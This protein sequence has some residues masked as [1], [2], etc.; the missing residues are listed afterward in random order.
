MPE[1]FIA[2][3]DLTV[4]KLQL[5]YDYFHHTGEKAKANRFITYLES[6]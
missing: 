5:L 2:K 6:S 1:S 4:R 3:Y